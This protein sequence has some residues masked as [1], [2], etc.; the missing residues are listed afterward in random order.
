M[1]RWLVTPNIRLEGAAASRSQVSRIFQVGAA[2]CAT[3]P[4]RSIAAGVLTAEVRHAR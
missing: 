4:S 1:E 3:G 2:V